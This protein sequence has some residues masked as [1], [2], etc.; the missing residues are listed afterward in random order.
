VSVVAIGLLSSLFCVLPLDTLLKIISGVG[1]LTQA[2]P[3]VIALIVIRCCRRHITLP[4]R[5]WGYPLPA[6]V[7]LGGFVFI[8]FS[9]E[10]RIIFVAIAF[11][12]LCS[13]MFVVRRSLTAH[14][15]SGELR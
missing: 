1:L 13:A 5:M 7:A 11:V 12:L 4:F 9:N 2:I 6:I 3:Q 10:P 14:Q 15:H 8:L